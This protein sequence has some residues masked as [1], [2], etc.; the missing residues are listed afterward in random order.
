MSDNLI[1]EGLYL[2]EEYKY[3]EAIE[4]FLRAKR[5]NPKDYL[6]WWI[7]GHA[8][9][10]NNQY[11]KAIDCFLK[12]IELGVTYD[13]Y[14]YD[15][16]LE[17]KAYINKPTYENIWF[18]LGHTYFING[19]CKEAIDCYLKSKEINASPGIDECIG[20]A[21]CKMGQYEEAIDYFLT[22]K[23]TGGL[24]TIIR[25]ANAY[26][27]NGQFN[28]AV[29]ILLK[30]IEEAKKS[31]VF[32]NN[33]SYRIDDHYCSLAFLYLMNSDYEKAID[34]FL[35]AVP[36]DYILEDS[37]YII[38]MELEDV[39]KIEGLYEKSIDYLTKILET[40]PNN[41][42]SYIWGLLGISCYKMGK[43]V[44]ID[45]FLNST[46]L[47][48]DSYIIWSLL[49]ILYILNEQY[50]EALEPLLT[51]TALKPDRYEAWYYLGLLYYKSKKYNEAIKTLWKAAKLDIFYFK[52]IRGYIYNSVNNIY[53]KNG[54]FKDAGEFY[55]KS[56]GISSNGYELWVMLGNSYCEIGQY[57]K[58]KK[59]Y[60]K[61]NKLN[62]EDKVSLEMIEKLNP[63]LKNKEKEEAEKIEDNIIFKRAS[64]NHPYI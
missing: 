61:A 63:I 3:E 50:E 56:I 11:D 53:Y 7:L 24:R 9:K 5:I 38:C 30:S 6:V 2:L 23:A 60:L 44:A 15:W 29:K 41:N 27:S 22:Y 45:A 37:K 48:H 13:S 57:D 20:D 8:Y 12:V 39:Y 35:E 26:Y 36:K 16:Y 18:A 40:E 46:E 28:E 64:K 34:Y 59:S 33:Y 17:N 21:Y 54:E 19:K 14:D 32:I 62:P 25:L 52:D 55:L 31:S 58:A 1:K 51:A 47:Y 10:R 49:G 43:Q 4:I 42:L